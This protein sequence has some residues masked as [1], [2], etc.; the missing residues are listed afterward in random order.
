MIGFQA[1]CCPFL[2]SLFFPKLLLQVK[3]DAADGAR[4]LQCAGNCG[5]FSRVLVLTG[6]AETTTA[7]KKKKSPGHI[8]LSNNKSEGRENKQRAGKQEDSLA[9]HYA[10]I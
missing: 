10:R 4:C 1:S 2:F 6:L 9:I 8:S 3:S 5:P 7:I